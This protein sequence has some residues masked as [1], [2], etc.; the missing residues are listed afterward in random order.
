[1]RNFKT[2]GI[3]IKKQSIGEKDYI[4]TLFTPLYGKIQAHAHGAKEISS[5]FTGHLD[6]LN[7]CDFQ[8]YKSTK[9]YTI[10]ECH[11]STSFCKFRENLGK[12]YFAS[13]IAKLL[14]PYESEN[15]NC[16]DIYA[17][18]I[19]TF[20]ALENLNKEN[21]I[22]EAFKIKLFALLG[23]MPDVYCIEE[24]EFCKNDLRFKK[25]L[26]FVL[27]EPYSNIIKLAL[28]EQD[29]DTLETLTKSLIGYSPI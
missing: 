13:E 16:E 25:L 28:N 27:N 11:L 29:T 23:I 6:L 26:K 19:E 18:L 22:F 17:L 15:D 2:Q 9:T 1:M 4:L 7:V 8:L 3:I 14:K 12:F 20:T 21:L 24:T 10:T 5:K